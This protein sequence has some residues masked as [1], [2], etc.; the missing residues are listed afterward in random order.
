M[1]LPVIIGGLD[2]ISL[3]DGAGYRDIE[4]VKR[5]G[6][7]EVVPRTNYLLLRFQKDTSD[8]G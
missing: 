6:L 2:N 7:H 5:F 1:Q 8:G 3:V 4:L